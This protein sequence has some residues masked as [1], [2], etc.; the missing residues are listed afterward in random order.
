MKLAFIPVALM[1]AL[2]AS[3][4]DYYGVGSIGVN[5]GDSVGGTGNLTGLADE[6]RE[7]GA[8]FTLGLGYRLDSNLRIEGRVTYRDNDAETSATGVVFGIP[9]QPFERSGKLSSKEISVNVIYDFSA[10]GAWT[11]YVKGGIGYAQN[12]YSGS[13]GGDLVA[14]ALAANGAP[15]SEFTYAEN[16]ESGIT[17]NI[18][19]GAERA[20]N[21]T[22]SLFAEYQYTNLGEVT[23]GLDNFGTP[24]DTYT[25]ANY[26]VHEVNLGLRFAF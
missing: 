8:S 4:Q 3:A 5:Y 12:K 15:F 13:L 20:I 9:D 11:P 7:I 1:M 17:W 25:D 6:S 2:P 14:G 26:G 23:S 10:M 21:D 19:L 18:G 22:T 16:S 24:G